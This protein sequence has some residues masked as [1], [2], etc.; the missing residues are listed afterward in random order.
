M[1]TQ[2]L[3][4]NEAEYVASLELRRWCDDHKNHC[5]VPE[6]LLKHWGMQVDNEPL[7]LTRPAV[8]RRNPLL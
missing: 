3:G 1:Y 7:E 8:M 5:Y 2:E 6:W 4:L